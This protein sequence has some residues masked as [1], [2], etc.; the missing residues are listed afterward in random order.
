M[1]LTSTG[2][3]PLRTL[4]WALFSLGICFY[5]LLSAET[6]VAIGFPYTASEGSP[7]AKFHPGTYCLLF[8]WLVA[9]ASHGNPVEALGWQFARHRLL[10][11]Y[12]FC[13]VLVFF[14]VLYRH[15]VSGIAAIVE[16]LWAPAIGVFA[17]Y[18][19]APN[20]QR[21]IIPLVGLL[22]AVNALIAIAE[23]LTGTRFGPQVDETGFVEE[24]FRASALLG[25]PL[26]GAQIF[27]S[28]LPVLTLLHWPLLVRLM[29]GLLLV[30]SLFAFGGR[31]SL[32]MGFVFYGG[33]TLFRMFLAVVRGRFSYLQLTGGSLALMLGT[34]IVAGIIAA[35]GIGERFFQKLY[36]DDSASVRGRVWDAFSFLSP[37]DLWTGIA[38]AEI[39]RISL[40]MG[41][42]PK[43]EAIENF[44]IYLLMQFG[45]VGYFPFILGIVLLVVLLWRTAT[46]WMRVAVFVYFLVASSANTLAS[47]TSSLTLLAVVIVA[48]NALRHRQS[49]PDTNQERFQ[50]TWHGNA[51]RHG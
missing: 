38:P 18:L 33:Y 19:L 14:W 29:I 11:G 3:P 36:W 17:L 21:Q 26:N 8:A 20:R 50:P 32:S 28:L 24:Y 12:F 31:A 16:S 23:F 9:L 22:L 47:K 1:H 45:I 25:H 15:G 42:D 6:L 13:M 40:R 4:A 34:T 7:L 35:S 43:S 49:S 30:L 46:P 48:G 39:D 2:E 27:V 44:W 41:L 10:T 51:E 37:T 5:L